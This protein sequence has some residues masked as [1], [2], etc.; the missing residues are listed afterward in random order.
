MPRLRRGAPEPLSG[1]R[2]PGRAR[3]RFLRPLRSPPRGRR[4]ASR[5]LEGRAAGP[6]SYTPRHLAERILSTRAALEGE[7]KHVTVLFADV[8]DSSVI[9]T[10][11]G[12]D[13][14]HALIDGCFA[15]LLDEVHRYEGT[16]NLAARLQA[17]APAGAVLLSETTAPLV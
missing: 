16:V 15:L 9:A 4:P 8:V 2:R 14:K 7:R 5:R 10:R 6:A 12:V 3:Q 17:A 11:L 13:E 1:V